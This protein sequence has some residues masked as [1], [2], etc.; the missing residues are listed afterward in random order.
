M[1][2]TRKLAARSALLG[3]LLTVTLGFA[4]EWTGFRGNNGSAVS[5]EKSIPTKWSKTEGIRWK[6]DLP[7]RGLSNPVI[8]GGKVYVTAC[9]S[10]KERRLHVLCF[11]EATG[12]KLWARQIAATGSTACHPET[13]MAAPTPVTDGKNVYALFATADL[14]AFDSEG[15]MLWYRSLVGDYPDLSNQVGMASSP[16]LIGGVLILPMENA[17][18]SFLAGVD[19]KTGE[20]K[21]RIKREREINW[22]TPFEIKTQGKTAGL[23]VTRSEALAFDP[24]TGKE[25][26]R[27][28]DEGL[29]SI[30]SATQGAGM[31][32]VPGQGV[33][34][35]LK[36]GNT[37]SPE[38][39]WE[40]KGVT[41]GY[42]SPVYYDGNLYGLA[43]VTLNCLD[44]KDGKERWKQR[45]TGPFNSSPVIANGLIYVTNARGK[46][47]VIEPGDKA[48][49]VAENDIEDKIQATPAFANGC[50]Y[51]RSDKALYCIGA[52]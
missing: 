13:N 19:V 34:R 51:L 41:G 12:K 22:T 5:S 2:L 15:T 27:Y 31:I 9:T 40:A 7:G 8:A 48:K 1:T 44:A 16:A 14:V 10:Y 6:V 46:T 43:S 4:A 32:F 20:N 18:D 26:W 45:V 21:W 39:A 37:G 49:V 30:P 29:S 33:L 38:V 50:I 28:T 42:P 25:I 52:K 17:G 36:P 47:Y 3:L 23:A 11:D 24:Q 35:A